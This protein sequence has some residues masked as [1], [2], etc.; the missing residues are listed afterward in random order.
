MYVKK[1]NCYLLTTV[2]IL[3][4]VSIL[5]LTKILFSNFMSFEWGSVSDWFSA[6]GTLGTLVVA[7]AAYRKAPEWM[8]QKHYDI[9]HG[10]VEKAVYNDLT[11]LSSSNKL[12]KA[13]LIILSRNLNRLLIEKKVESEFITEVAN[14]TDTI[15]SDFFNNSYSVINQLNSIT[16]NNFELSEYT[17]TIIDRLK[18][19]S[20][21][22]NYIYWD[23]LTAREEIGS[24]VNADQQAIDLTSAEIKSIEERAN[25]S[26]TELDDLIKQI[27]AD[28]LPV[29]SF[30]S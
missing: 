24:L 2:L 17:Q 15:L 19:V 21:K 8:A 25:N 18:S 12:L 1:W 7:V 11:L 28:N 22:Y 4:I 13:N 16:R 3:L 30:I 10:I 23:Y 5:V 26:A 6:F 20:E 27:F 9:V 14:R 29:K